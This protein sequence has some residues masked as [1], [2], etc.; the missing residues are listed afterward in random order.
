MPKN[1]YFLLFF[2]IFYCFANFLGINLQKNPY[3]CYKLEK[4]T[5]AEKT[6]YAY[7]V[8]PQW[9]DF[10]MRASVAALTNAVLS[11]AGVDAQRKGFGTDTLNKEN[12]S[13]VLLRMA[14]EFDHRP[15]QYTDFSITTWV[16]DYGRMMSTR[17]FT[18]QDN[19]GKIFGRVV[20]QWCMIDLTTRRPIDLTT[21]TIAENYGKYLV[22][23]PSPTEAPKRLGAIDAQVKVVRDVVYSDIDF[24]RHVNTLRY[25]EMMLDRLPLERFEQD[26]PL[27]L[28]VNFQHECRYGQTLE[29][30]YEEREECDLF[31]ISSEGTAAVRA[32]LEWR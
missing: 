28:D 7:R 31:E 21:P 32:R 10:T 18:V 12:F 22:E 16:S 26:R 4:K 6:H 8:D 27:R 5:M 29:I 25:L 13:W 3:F 20:T 24:N 17:N 14:V 1:K 30:G 19:E 15:E 11:V 9:V 23:C 2:D